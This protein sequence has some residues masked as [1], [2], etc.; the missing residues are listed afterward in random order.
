MPAYKFICR[1]CGRN[2]HRHYKTSKEYEEMCYGNQP[3]GMACFDCGFPQMVTIRTEKPAPDGFKPGFQRSIMKHCATRKEFEAELKRQGLVELGNEDFPEMKNEPDFRWT[4]N[5]FK[6]VY[7]KYGINTESGEA[8]EIVEAVKK[9][10]YD[11]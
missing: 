7:Q 11:D 4:E 2:Y 1:K 3:P 5:F 9:Q 10:V 6:K 8:K